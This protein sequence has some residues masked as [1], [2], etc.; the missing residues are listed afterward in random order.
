MALPLMKQDEQVVLTANPVHVGT[1]LE[2]QPG[3][4]LMDFFEVDW[5][6]SVASMREC[7]VTPKW[8][9]DK[10]HPTTEANG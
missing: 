3:H 10:W 1:L 5:G 8:V 9:Y 7:E 6:D 2:D 4:G